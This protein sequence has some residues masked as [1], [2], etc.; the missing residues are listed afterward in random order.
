[1]QLTPTN[2]LRETALEIAEVAQA[3]GWDAP[4]RLY[5]LVRTAALAADEPALARELGIG[6]DDVDDSFTAV[7]QDDLPAERSFED[8]V[9]E[10]VWPPQVDGTAVV[11]ERLMLPPDA[12]ESLPDDESTVSDFVAEHPDRQ[13]VRLTVAVTRDGQAH[14]IVDVRGSDELAEGPDLVPGLVSMLRQTL[15][16]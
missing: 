13:E 11:L 10:I 14:C 6:P 9:T 7:E 8:F 16:D 12:E 4:P 2:A 15:L 1:M 5:A 3:A